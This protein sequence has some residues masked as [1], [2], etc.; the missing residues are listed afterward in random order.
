MISSPHHLDFS[1][2]EYLRNGRY[3]RNTRK[4]LEIK[5]AML[6]RSGKKFHITYHSGSRALF[7]IGTVSAKPFVVT[8][9]AF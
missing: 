6:K 7:I 3:K 4:F 5:S 8:I 1:K 9:S 2:R